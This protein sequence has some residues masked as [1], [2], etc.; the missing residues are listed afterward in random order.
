VRRAADPSARQKFNVFYIHNIL[1][2]HMHKF[3]LYQKST[4]FE[5]SLYAGVEKNGQ[6]IRFQVGKKGPPLGTIMSD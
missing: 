6:E 1:V 2:V 5:V 4:L 3:S